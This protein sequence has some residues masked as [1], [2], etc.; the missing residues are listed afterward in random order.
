MERRPRPKRSLSQNF[1]VDPNLRRKLVASLQAAS[2]DTVVEVGAGHGELSEELVG[3]V[4]RLVLV[5][6]D[7]ALAAELRERWGDRPDVWVVLGDAL[8]LDLSALADGPGPLR[9]ISNIPYGITT[10]LIFRLLELRPTPRRLLVTV[11][12]EVAERIV[13]VPGTPAYGALTVGVQTKANARVAFSL[14]RQAFRPVPAVDSAAVIIEPF[15]ERLA[16]TDEEALRALTRTAFARRRKQLQKILRSS[17][18][19]ALSPEEVD[20]LCREIGLDPT[21]RPERLAP[22]RFLALARRIRAVRTD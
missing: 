8:E 12:K 19:F 15:E 16:P 18:E 11:Q 1:L 6:K 3:R 4:A 20:R 22:E 21:T 17:P 9:V 14:G 7:D 2:G 10:P 13:A 5:E